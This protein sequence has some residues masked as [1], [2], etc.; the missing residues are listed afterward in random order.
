MTTTYL[1]LLARGIPSTVANNL[2]AKGETL[3][4]LQEK[5]KDELVALRLS[6]ESIDAI[7]KTTRPPIPDKTVESLLIKC[8]STCCICRK[9]GKE[10]IIH[11]I[12]EWSESRSH[13]L[14]NLVVL[15]LDDH[16]KAH[17][18]HELSKNLT[19]ELIR[20][21][22]TQ[23]ENDAR[24]IEHNYQAA[25]LS[26]NSRS[27][28]WHWLH[29]ENVRRQTVNI[30]KPSYD[31]SEFVNRLVKAKM[32]SAAGCI[33]PSSEWQDEPFKA[34]KQYVFDSGLGQDL[35]LYCSDLLANWVKQAIVLDVN[36]IVDYP[37]SARAY[38]SAGTWVYLRKYFRVTYERGA[39]DEV[40][41]MQATYA[42]KSAHVSFGFNAW[43]RLNQSSR[44]YLTQN[45]E[46]S[47]IGQIQSISM[48]DGEVEIKLSPLA[49]SPEFELCDP[50]LGAW[51]KGQKNEDYKRR[52][53]KSE[54]K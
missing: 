1:A 23:W 42:S 51:V 40:D 10:F 4:T 3:A 30:E 8:R 18:K 32:L 7:L 26:S 16:G 38:L 46:R 6:E 20:A 9:P 27:V 17:S 22:R 28:R 24:R 52:L 44:L 47:V 11:H 35:A 49:I 41:F 12:V 15:C 2:V 29:L 33:R 54:R 43:T 21:H 36:S 37:D 34:K 48:N 50:S 31:D 13:D 25:L 14:D 53:K 39:A 45:S 19:P 5:R